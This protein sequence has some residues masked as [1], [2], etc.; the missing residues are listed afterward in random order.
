[1][2]RAGIRFYEELNDF[3]VPEKRKT[4][5]QVEFFEGETVKSIIENEGV[6]HTEVDLVTVNSESVS[7]EHKPTDGA[8]IQVYPVF[9][10]LDI[11]GLSK[12]RPEPLRD[13]KFILDIHLG[14]LARMLRMLGF[15]AVWEPPFEDRLIAERSRA[16]RR[17]V[18]TRDRG[19]LK[20][21]IVTHGYCIRSSDPERQASEVI[22]RFDLGRLRN[23]F[24]MCMACNTPLVERRREEILDRLPLCVTSL[25][26]FKE[27]P[28]CRNLYWKGSHWDRMTERIRR[29]DSPHQ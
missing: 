10:S 5:Y 24:T 22:A 13:P 29:L 7:F 9:E 27:C 21:S 11:A 16:E 1:M 3:L 19:L 28:S 4:V 25:T 20:R 18:L 2:P 26:E 8:L 23:P 14:K 15:D 12:V 6:P 17:I